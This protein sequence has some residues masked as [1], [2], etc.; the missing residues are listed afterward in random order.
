MIGGLSRADVWVASLPP[1]SGPRPV[2]IVTLDV[3]LPLLA[4]VTV[5]EVTRT[6]RDLPTAVPLG[7]PEGLDH[8][9]AVNCDNLV[10]VPQRLLRKRIGGLGPVKVR[11]LNEALRVALDLE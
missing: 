4:N 5:A 11:E 2:V 3:A 1:P 7:R 9:C 10:T 8:E 6:I